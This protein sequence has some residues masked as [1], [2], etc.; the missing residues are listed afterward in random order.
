MRKLLVRVA[1]AVLLG[2]LFGLHVYHDYMKWSRLGLAAFL[3][4]QTTRFDKFMA[5]PKS[6]IAI[7]FEFAIVALLVA[8]LYELMVAVVWKLAKTRQS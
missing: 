2:G 7:V 1:A 4:N 6:P 5:Y 3:A 8:G